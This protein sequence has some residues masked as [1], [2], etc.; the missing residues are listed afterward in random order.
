MRE[1]LR[2]ATER[3]EAAKVEAGNQ[4]AAATEH[5]KAAAAAAEA[6]ATHAA[7]ARAVC[8]LSSL[9]DSLHFVASA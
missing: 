9:I 3:E 1:Q 4:L 2:I 6:E 7:A 8:Y 5:A